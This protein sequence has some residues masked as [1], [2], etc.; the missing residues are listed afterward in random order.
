MDSTL[1]RLGESAN[2]ALGSRSFRRNRHERHAASCLR[3]TADASTTDLVYS[4][5]DTL[6]SQAWLDLSKEPVILSVPDTHGRYYLMQLHDAWT[7]VF[8]SLGKRTTGTEKADFAIMGPG[9]KGQPPKEVQEIR[10][11]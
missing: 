1:E 7:N 4:N 11:P 3:P 8:S 2:D 5:G 6:E 10:A 9:W